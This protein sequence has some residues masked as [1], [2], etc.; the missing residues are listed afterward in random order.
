MQV[1]GG[2]DVMVGRRTGPGSW[3]L[4]PAVV[5]S[6]EAAAGADCPKMQAICDF[7]DVV[8]LWPSIA[9]AP[10]GTIGI[11]YRDIHNGYTKDAQ[12]CSDLELTTSSGGGWGHQ[13]IDLG[14]GS[15]LFNSLAFD[16][17]GQ[18]AIAFY[19]GKYGVLTFDRR[20]DGAFTGTRECASNDDCPDGLECIKSTGWC[21]NVV[22]RPEKAMPAESISMQV[23]PD[24]TILIAYFDPDK[25]NLKIAYS[26]DGLSWTNGTIDSNGSTGLYPSLVIDP[27]TQLPIVAYYR[28]SDYA[29]G[30]MVCN[31]NQDGPRLAV[32]TGEWPN[33]LTEQNK[34]KKNQDLID[35]SDAD[36]T[37][38]QHIKVA[39]SPDGHVG[40]AYNYA[41]VDPSDGSSH[42]AVMFRLGTWQEQ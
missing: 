27:A 16:Q 12:D 8:G 41:W 20:K 31:H 25:K 5:N 26:S 42:Q 40:I 35:T 11:A 17:Q 3:N 18:P 30:D 7:G 24:G 29:P 4:N 33:E 13:W 37:D 1:C 6:N 2:T 22:A 10:D 38:G 14:R 9:V 36:A 39:I 15:G 19:N 28:C 21:W 23:A 34:W 32:F